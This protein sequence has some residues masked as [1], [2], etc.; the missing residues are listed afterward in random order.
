MYAPRTHL[1]KG[2]QR[3]QYYYHN[4]ILSFS[5]YN[6][7]PGSVVHN[8]VRHGGGFGGGGVGGGLIPFLLC[9]LLDQQL[10]LLR[11]PFAHRRFG[12]WQ[13]FAHRCF[14]YWQ[15]PSR[16]GMIIL[17]SWDRRNVKKKKS[18]RFHVFILS[19]S[20]LLIQQYCCCI[21]AQVTLSAWAS[22]I[23]TK[24]AIWGL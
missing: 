18:G 21:S 13:P 22:W 16:V 8:A 17:L 2:A 20:S 24:R 19:N 23:L 10:S 9:L 15:W 4:S 5:Q 7:H 6:T 14:G 3:P 11:Q 12:H 1:R